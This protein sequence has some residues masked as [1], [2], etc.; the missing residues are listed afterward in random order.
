V[1]AA[2]S[3]PRVSFLAWS[4]N[5]ARTADLASV[6]GGEGR[7]YYALQ[8][9]HRWAVPLRYLLDAGRTI[10]YL[11]SRRPRAVVVTN[12][13][14]FPALIALAY[15][16]MARVPLVLDSHIS[17]FGLA[18]DRLSRLLL[19]LHAWLVRRVD[20]TLVS[21]DELAA[22]VRRWGGR[23]DIVHE[24]PLAGE[25]S[26]AQ[27]V[28]ERPRIL[29]VTIFSG[30]E[31]LEA[32]I[33]AAAAVPSVDVHVTGDLRRCPPGV[34]AS[35]P[36]NVTFV[37]YLRG[38]RYTAALGDADVVLTLSNERNSVMRTAYEA[39]YARRPLIVPDRPLLRALFPYAVHV[40]IT[41][42]GIAMGIRTALDRHTELMGVAQEARTLQEERW[43]RQRKTLE[44][45]I[46]ARSFPADARPARPVSHA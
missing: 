33:D 45:L 22:V 43:R 3:R 5:S 6:F 41:A 32:V 23:A 12:P 1:P 24:P 11:M 30:D 2:A 37:G 34:R 38:E 20:S 19:P 25:L 28:R 15:A 39:V 14:I 26:A 46:E 10:A 17:A 16:R 35:A 18:G 27:G 42:Q 44:S 9:V 21:D 40:P 31:P 8:L 13:P 4:V 7:A 36:S 29:Y